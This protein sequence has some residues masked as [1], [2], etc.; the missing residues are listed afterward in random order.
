MITT[1]IFFDRYLT[2]GTLFS[3][4]CDPIRGFAVIIALL[5]PLLEKITLDWLV[6][7]LTT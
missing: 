2:F 5:L 7:I 1:A 4:G 3:I 6:P